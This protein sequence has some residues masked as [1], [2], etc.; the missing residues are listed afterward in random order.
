MHWNLKIFAIN[1]VFLL[2]LWRFLY[3]LFIAECCRILFCVYYFKTFSFSFLEF[4]WVLINGLRFDVASLSLLLLPFFLFH[5]WPL[6]AIQTKFEKAIK[7]YW[8]AVVIC[9]VLLNLIDTAY[10]VYSGKRS[11][12]DLFTI[13]ANA[14][15]EFLIQ[16]P[17]YILEYWHWWLLFFIF[18]IFVWKFYPKSNSYSEKSINSEIAKTFFVSILYSLLLFIGI[19]GGVQGRPIKSIAASEF[20]NPKY[21][22]AVLNT[23]FTII[24]TIGEQNIETPDFFLNGEEEKLW[25]MVHQRKGNVSDFNN[26]NIVII[27]VESLG[28]EWMGYFGAEKTS[29]PFLDSLCQHSFVCTN[30]YAN[31]QRSIEG[32][33]AI[34]SSNPGLSEEAFI[35]SSYGGTTQLTSLANTLNKYNYHSAFFHGGNNGTMAFDWYFKLIDF[36]EYYGRKEFANPK[37]FDGFWGVPDF[38]FLE[39]AEKKISEFNAPFVAGIF[40]LS[41]H[42]PYKVPTAFAQLK[43]YNDYQKSLLYADYSLKNFFE[44]AKKQNWFNQT[45]FVITAD[46][47]SISK[48]PFYGNSV[49]AFAIPILFYSPNFIEPKHY[50]LPCQQIDI[51]PSL[52]GLLNY[53]NQYISAGNDIFNE[54]K[55]GALM[56]VNNNFQFVGEKSVLQFNGQKLLASYATN[57]SLLQNNNPIFLDAKEYNLAKAFVQNYFNRLN[58]NKLK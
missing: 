12:A 18:L 42:H 58:K 26:K 23:T 40:T 31:A 22:A 47:T 35:T 5:I 19:R 49:G 3:S 43:E 1:K 16:A 4:L 32:I 28:K 2:F 33:P 39:F 29:T 54:Q 13:N 52:L 37:I 36:K 6:N 45:V 11:T 25:P 10:F 24:T 48:K 30:A 51:L 44:K 50:T 17:K 41:S 57:D 9:F 21:S 15:Q 34:F 38:E 8:F 55:Y 27:V 20:V 7:I 56:L 14:G 46:H 53:P